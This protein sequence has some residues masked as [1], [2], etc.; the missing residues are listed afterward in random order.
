MERTK[1]L[2]TRQ[3]ALYEHLKTLFNKNNE[4]WYNLRDLCDELYDFEEYIYLSTTKNFNNERA[5]RIMTS[6]IQVLKDSDIIPKVILSSGNGVK[7][8]NEKEIKEELEKEKISLLSSLQRLNKQYRKAKLDGQY[9]LVF[10]QERDVVEV[11]KCN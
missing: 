9:R 11:Y 5:R 6:D 7:I 4:K 10:G 3:W 2:N 8:A 1:E